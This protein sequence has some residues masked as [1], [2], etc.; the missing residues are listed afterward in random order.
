MGNGRAEPTILV[1]VRPA[2]P[3]PIGCINTGTVQNQHACGYSLHFYIFKFC[4]DGRISLHVTYY[5]WGGASLM[6]SCWALFPRL[7]PC[8]PFALRGYQNKLSK[9]LPLYR[10]C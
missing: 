1:I 9:L 10:K 6:V 7:L 2:L 3:F 5:A 8:R 4:F